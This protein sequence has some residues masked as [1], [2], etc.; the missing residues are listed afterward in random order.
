MSDFKYH[1]YLQKVV[2]EDVRFIKEREK[3]YKGSWCK[4]GGRSSWFMIRRKLD[5]LIEMMAKP[6][7]P[8]LFSLPCLEKLS[9]FSLETQEKMIDFMIDSLHAE[10][11]FLKIKQEPSGKD[12]TVLAEIR[13]L[14]RYLVLVESWCMA[15]GFIKELIVE[16]GY[17]YNKSGVLESL[18]VHPVDAR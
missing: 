13:D 17:K 16:N 11:I 7:E 3:L 9:E 1:D 6:D 5:R 12:S 14:R 4:G 8:K 10:D 15:N 2:D 18:E